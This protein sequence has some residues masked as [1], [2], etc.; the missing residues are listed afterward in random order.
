MA[1]DQLMAVEG[2][3]VGHDRIARLAGV[4]VGTVYRRFPTKDALVEAVLVERISEVVA[5]ARAGLVAADVW[6][7]LVGFLTTIVQLQ[8]D[9]CA[10]REL[11]A[12]GPHGQ[13]LAERARAEI[14]PVP[15]RSTN[16]SR[17]MHAPRAAPLGPPLKVA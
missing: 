9:S 15:A 4:A 1:A 17:P 10:L 16:T 7:G 11:V 5:A 3:G 14:S 12:G 13:I 6:E 8:V 2:L